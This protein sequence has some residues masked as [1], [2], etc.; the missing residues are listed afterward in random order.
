MQYKMIMRISFQF[1][2]NFYRLIIF[3]IHY[4]RTVE[5]TY[6][7]NTFR[8]ISIIYF[9]VLVSFKVLVSC[10]I[11]LLSTI[12]TQNNRAKLYFPG[13]NS[14]VSMAHVHAQSQA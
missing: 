1:I 6:I 11:V 9:E 14:I 10:H 2:F 5:H 8:C 3:G 12:T 4:T 13:Q 7:S